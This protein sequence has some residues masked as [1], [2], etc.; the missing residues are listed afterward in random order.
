MVLV[1]AIQ[2]Q[3][4]LMLCQ[5]IYI[6]KLIKSILF[7]ASD[8]I[9]CGNLIWYLGNIFPLLATLCLEFQKNKFY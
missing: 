4:I 2:A 1:E 9:S 5:F 7:Q 6:L 8:L 3:V